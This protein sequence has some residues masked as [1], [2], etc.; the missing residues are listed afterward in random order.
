MVLGMKYS[1]RAINSARLLLH[2]KSRMNLN[3]YLFHTSSP[4]RFIGTDPHS[5]P[6]SSNTLLTLSRRSVVLPCSI[7]AQSVAPLLLSPRG[8]LVSVYISCASPSHTA[9]WLSTLASY[10]DCLKFHIP[11]MYPKCRFRVHVPRI[12]TNFVSFG[13]IFKAYHYARLTP[14]KSLYTLSVPNIRNRNVLYL[15]SGIFFWVYNNAIAD[16]TSGET[17]LAITPETMPDAM[18]L[19]AWSPL[20]MI[21][22]EGLSFSISVF[23][24]SDISL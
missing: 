23:N 20:L 19:M 21:F 12:C 14:R 11:N 15:F 1:F 7:H 24:S 2:S 10:I 22:R 9:L 17:W 6:K 4:S 3:N 5:E 16:V 13:Y 8:L 18:P